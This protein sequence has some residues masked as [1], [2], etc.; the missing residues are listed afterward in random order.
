MIVQSSKTDFSKIREESEK[1][2]APKPAAPPRQKLG[3]GDFLHL[4]ISQL[5]YQDPLHPMNNTRFAAQLAQFSQLDQLTHLNKGVGHMVHSGTD[6]NKMMMVGFLGQEV[7]MKGNSF[8]LESGGSVGLRFRQGGHSGSGHLRI[9]DEQHHLVRTIALKPMGAGT[10][11]V[12]WDGVT[13]Q[14]A[15]A[16]KGQYSFEVEAMDGRHKPIPAVPVQTGVVTGILF[17]KGEPVL[18]VNGKPVAFKE[19]SHVGRPAVPPRRQPEAQSPVLSR[20]LAPLSSP[21][22]S[23][24]GHDKPAR[25]PDAIH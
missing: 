15:Q 17:E 10:H 22:A 23:V 19:I 24:A 3:M 16:P 14:G 9:F 8:R 21:T 20:K 13:N 7:T 11:S 6:A 12:S 18:E 25:K 5:Q 1:R 4:M 2:L